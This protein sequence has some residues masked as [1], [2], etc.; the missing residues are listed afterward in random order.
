[1]VNPAYA[2][3]VYQVNQHFVETNFA[4][5]TPD[6]GMLAKF[7]NGP[8]NMIWESLDADPL[9]VSLASEARSGSWTKL[10]SSD[11]VRAYGTSLQSE[12]ANLFLVFKS[13]KPI[14]GAV[15]NTTQWPPARSVRFVDPILQEE[16]WWPGL[17][18]GAR[19]RVLFQATW[20]C[21]IFEAL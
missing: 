12:Y 1:M 14:F 11:C 19:S 6:L 17:Q 7:D 21:D 5:P 9:F 10:A 16:T 18:E 13:S 15:S 20:I 8:S 3:N 4:L 2:Y